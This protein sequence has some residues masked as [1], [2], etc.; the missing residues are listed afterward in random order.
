M[1]TTRAVE[2]NATVARESQ[3]MEMPKEI[4][5]LM[6]GL[7][8]SEPLLVEFLRAHRDVIPAQSGVYVFTNYSDRLEANHG[9]LYVGKARSLH[10]RLQSYLVAPNELRLLSP[11]AKDGRISRSLRH[12]GKVQ[13]LME[14]NQRIAYSPHLR[15]EIWVRWHLTDDAERLEKILISGLKPAF[16]STFNTR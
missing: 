1:F 6:D 3:E 2:L 10:G 9:V 16:N 13:L 11:R 14:I 15:T 5:D 4:T 12:A 7:A 8:W